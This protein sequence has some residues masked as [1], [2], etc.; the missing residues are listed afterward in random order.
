MIASIWWKTLIEAFRRWAGKKKKFT[1]VTYAID[2]I[3][4]LNNIWQVLSIV[5]TLTTEIHNRFSEVE[6]VLLIHNVW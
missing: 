3:D 2:S 5:H 6:W 1:V 4:I